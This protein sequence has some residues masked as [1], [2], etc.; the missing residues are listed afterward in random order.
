MRFLMLGL[1]RVFSGAISP[2]L[3]AFAI[4]TSL[5]V[6][7][8]IPYPKGTGWVKDVYLAIGL[9]ALIGMI[10]TQWKITRALGDANTQDV[11]SVGAW[12]GWSL[13]AYLPAVILLVGPIAVWGID[14]YN[15][16]MDAA[17]WWLVST[18]MMA[19]ASSI[20]PVSVHA[21]GRA[22]D[23]DGPSLADC[24]RA[25]APVYL[26]L[27]LSFFISS[28]AF[29]L[30]SDWLIEISPVDEFSLTSILLSAAS[31]LLVL[32]SFVW[33]TAIVTLAWRMVDKSGQEEMD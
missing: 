23:V 24:F 27:A 26:P 30:A 29:F 17:P 5:I 12:I 31:T 15:A 2:Q 1:E 4:A 14:N 32:A 7:F 13:V 18:V 19:T 10:V 8:A 20:V 25:C 9:A 22:I 33:S 11:G 21:A 16:K 28:T 6:E 3:W